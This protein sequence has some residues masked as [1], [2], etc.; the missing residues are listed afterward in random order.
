MENAI[1]VLADRI[2]HRKRLVAFTGAGISTESG[3]SDYRSKGGLWDRFQPIYFDEFM[4]SLLAE[5]I[6]WLRDGRCTE[7]I[8][9]APFRIALVSD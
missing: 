8:T 2:K 7:Y 9:D 5:L 4:S 3:I 6:N 1:H